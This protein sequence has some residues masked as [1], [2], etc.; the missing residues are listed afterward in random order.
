[1]KRIAQTSKDETVKEEGAQNGVVEE[2]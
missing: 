1:M 2:V